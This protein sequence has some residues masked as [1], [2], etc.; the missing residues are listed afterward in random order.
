MQKY[1][2]RLII[3]TKGSAVWCKPYEKDKKY[4]QILYLFYKEGIKKSYACVELAFNDGFISQNDLDTMQ[5]VLNRAKRDLVLYKD[6]LLK[7]L[8]NLWLKLQKN[9]NKN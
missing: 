9:K 3:A 1:G 6:N 8:E 5:I 7:E 2:Y 4:N